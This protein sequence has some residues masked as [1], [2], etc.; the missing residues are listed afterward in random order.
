MNYEQTQ[1]EQ[2]FELFKSACIHTNKLRAETVRGYES[3]FRT[4]T[5]LMPEVVNVKDINLQTLNIFFKSLDTR[6][7]VVGK[8]TK[9]QGVRASTI[10]SYANKLNT[11]FE[12]LETHGYMEQGTNPIP[13]IKLP[14]PQYDDKKDLERHQIEKLYSAADRYAKNLLLSKRDKAMLSVLLFCGVRRGELLG[15]RVTDVD[16]TKRTIRIRAESSKSKAE[17]RVPLNHEAYLHL[18]DYMQERKRRRDTSEYLFI[19]GQQDNRFTQHGL[20]HWV[21]RLRRLSGVRFHLHQF[22]HTFAMT[23]MRKGVHYAKIQRLMGHTDLRMTQRYL[24]SLTVEDMRDDI[25]A[26]SIDDLS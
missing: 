18:E 8:N 20:K 24:R 13:K 15:L 16:L 4:F 3:V 12:W 5:K 14:S 2:Y 21:Q 10:C 25:D 1:L 7:R 22:R 17:R 26:L 23:L 11:F 6:V 19:S 9:K